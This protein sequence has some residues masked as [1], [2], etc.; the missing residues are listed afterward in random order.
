M[1]RQKGCGGE[2][3]DMSR[4]VVR[5][6]VMPTA[7]AVSMKHELASLIGEAFSIAD[8]AAVERVLDDCCLSGASSA[9]PVGDDA[10]TLEEKADASDIQA[11]RM[12][13]ESLR[14][15]NA[16]SLTAAGGSGA[17]VSRKRSLVNS[18]GVES[19]HDLSMMTAGKGKTVR[20]GQC[21]GSSDELSQMSLEE[22]R[23]FGSDL[24]AALNAHDTSDS[25]LVSSTVPVTTDSNSSHVP[26][27]PPK[28]RVLSK[29]TGASK[30]DPVAWLCDICGT[31]NHRRNSGLP[32]PCRST[33]SDS[34]EMKC[35]ACAFRP[36]TV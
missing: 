15:S 2:E 17:L 5:R 13:L 34:A 19:S 24:D 16:S 23:R 20:E 7:R 28:P 30:V 10:P 21:A 25:L 3:G 32:A 14:P 4:T 36:K 35:V 31:E 22:L 9:K 12:A 33:S 11:L 18:A 26:S 6:K 1:S 27:P 29:P 8:P